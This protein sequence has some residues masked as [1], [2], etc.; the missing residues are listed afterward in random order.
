MGHHQDERSGAGHRLQPAGRQ[1]QVEVVRQLQAAGAE[2]GDDALRVTVDAPPGVDGF[3]EGQRV[4]GGERGQPPHL[5]EGGQASARPGAGERAEPGLPDRQ[6]G[7]PD[8]AGLRQERPARDLSRPSHAAPSH[9]WIMALATL[10]HARSAHRA[11]P[12]RART[13]RCSAP[14]PEDRH[15]LAVLRRPS[16]A[17]ERDRQPHPDPEVVVRALHDLRHH[18]GALG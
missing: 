16:P 13:E 1:V 14:G 2:D 15:G 3:R 10:P 7:V 5:G 18:P 8:S 17:P 9:P 6:T 11:L 4:Q 12:N